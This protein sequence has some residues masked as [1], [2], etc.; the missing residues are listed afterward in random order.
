M[1]KRDSNW[2]IPADWMFHFGSLIIFASITLL[3]GLL[4]PILAELKSTELDNLYGWG[5]GT[6]TFGV[7][8]LFLA[9]QP[10]Y[11]QRRFWTIGPR[12]LD[13]KHRVLYW[14]AYTAVAIC[15]LLLCLVWMKIHQA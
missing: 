11:R 9:R 13:R 7:F 10:L 8:L 12:H 14:L 15:L 3:A 1:S 2:S 4:L 5:V 6:G